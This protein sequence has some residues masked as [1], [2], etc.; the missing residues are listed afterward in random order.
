MFIVII[1]CFWFWILF[2]L[3][4]DY[5]IMYSF[6][7]EYKKARKMRALILGFK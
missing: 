2:K 4:Y 6:S 1:F 7:L 3:I 5:I